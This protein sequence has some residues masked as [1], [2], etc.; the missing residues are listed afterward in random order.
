[1]KWWI[2]NVKQRP[3]RV[4][5]LNELGFLWQRLQPEW[6][7]VLEALITFKSTFGH[8]L[9][10]TKFVVPFGN[11][12]WPRATWGI[13]LGDC[14]YRIRARND[15]LRGSSYDS[16]REQLD[17][18]GF[19]W[20]VQEHRFR[21]FYGTLRHFARLNEMG[22]FSC[23]IDG[24]AARAEPLCVPSTYTVPQS[25]EWPRG[26]WG[27][28]LGAR[29]TAVRQKEL[30]IKGHPERRFMLDELGF[31]WSG[32]ADFG[33]LRVSHAAAIYSRMHQR[34]L[35]VPY[36]FTVPSPPKDLIDRDEW[37]WPEYLWGLPLGQRLK[38]VRSKGAYL[39]GEFA[40]KRRR[41][42]DTLGF[43]WERKKAGRPK[44]RKTP[45]SDK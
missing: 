24:L 9:V 14:V 29:C 25:P 12:N 13:N 36:K 35:D 41:Q 1:M 15:F 6:N 7:L 4:E 8:V 34:K 30:Y 20:D 26:V 27:Y 5:Q 32:N 42:L 10:P 31:H 37:P 44:T 23:S 45:L 43:N 22:P 33:W 18:L 16:R 38:D 2:R 17:G 28:P 39:R 11:D 3:E 19:V 21:T 40:E